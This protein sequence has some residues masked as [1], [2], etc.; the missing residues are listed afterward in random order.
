MDETS[1]AED[2]SSK[3]LVKGLVAND[4]DPEKAAPVPVPDPKLPKLKFKQS[5]VWSWR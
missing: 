4:P 1:A 3:S 2:V 5:G